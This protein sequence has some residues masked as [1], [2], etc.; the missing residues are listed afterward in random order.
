M[1]IAGRGAA[2]VL[3]PLLKN[4]KKFCNSYVKRDMRLS[5]ASEPAVWF[6]EGMAGGP[7]PVGIRFP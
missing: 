6:G 7:F 4:K 3:S 5:S 1:R 2:P